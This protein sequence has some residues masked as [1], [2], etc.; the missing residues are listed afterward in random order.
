M[1]TIKYLDW[2]KM[3]YGQAWEKQQ[4]I[5]DAQIVHKANKTT[6]ENH[7]IFV[8]HPHVYTL[9]KSG[10]NQNL[11]ISDEIL[12]KI[13]ATYYKVDRGGDIT[14]HGP[15]QIVGYPI[16]DL[17]VMHV[18]YK[19]YIEKLETA[20]LKYLK[21]CHQL[22]VFQLDSATG[23]WIKTK[24]GPEKICAIGTKASRY[25][26]MHGFALNINTDLSY[27][28]YINP[29]GFKDKG[30]TSLEKLKGTKCDFE[31]EK[32]NLTNYIMREFEGQIDS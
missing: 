19:G 9:G 30:V 3:D 21:E 25:I 29:C 26:T 10:D 12:K 27:F 32:K 6:T 5:F 2:G 16:F 23:V 24:N 8:E 20:I 28:E 17:E 7:L 31:L 11:L 18:T 14:Y 4:K 1:N 13:N 22:D 15:G